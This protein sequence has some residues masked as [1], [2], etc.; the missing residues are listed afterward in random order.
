M[1]NRTNKPKL[2]PI[3]LANLVSVN[4][5]DE[6]KNSDQSYRPRISTRH[7]LLQPLLEDEKKLQQ[8]ENVFEDR[9]ESVRESRITDCRSTTKTLTGGGVIFGIIFIIGHVVS[10]IK[11]NLDKDICPNVDFEYLAQQSTCNS[12]LVTNLTIGCNTSMIDDACYN[13]QVSDFMESCLYVDA[14][15]FVMGLFAAV[16]HNVFRSICRSFNDEEEV[17]NSTDLEEARTIT[18]RELPLANPMDQYRAV[19][20]NKVVA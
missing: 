3:S 8:F 19:S 12:S 11:Y 4:N 10:H 6:E 7:N 5:F 18:N 9:L 1:N 2:E 13:L 20:V 17:L 15:L 14:M 16:G